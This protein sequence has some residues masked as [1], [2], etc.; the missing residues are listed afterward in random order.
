MEEGIKILQNTSVKTFTPSSTE[1]CF[2]IIIYL[3]ENPA[4]ISLKQANK[5]VKQRIIDVLCGAATAYQMGVCM[6]DKNNIL[7]I[8]K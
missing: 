7:I 4:L 3:K 6:V 8:K 5:A 1:D 2:E